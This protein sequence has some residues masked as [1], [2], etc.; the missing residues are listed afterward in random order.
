M[1]RDKARIVKIEKFT[2]EDPIHPN[3]PK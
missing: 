1:V 3:K 2:E